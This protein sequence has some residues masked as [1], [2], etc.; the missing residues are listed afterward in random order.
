MSE[1]VRINKYMPI[2]ILYFFFNGFLLPQG[3]LYTAIL[4]PVLLLWLYK[5]PSFKYIKYFFL[6]TIP[7]AI[8]HFINGVVTSYYLIS[9]SLLFTVFVFGLSF[10][11][12]LLICKSYRRI[13]SNLVLLNFVFFL[14]AVIG[15]TIPWLKQLLWTSSYMSYNIE[16]VYR[17]RM[18]TYE[19]SYYSTLLVPIAVYYYIKALRNQLTDWFF[20][21]LMVS[22][23]LLLSF[24]FGVISGMI[25]ALAVMLI[26]NLGA[27]FGKRKAA[28]YILIG[29]SL[30]FA[31]L[32]V[33]FVFFPDNIFFQRL[34]NVFEGR[35]SS[36]RG[37]THDSLFLAWEVAKMKSTIFGVGL[38]QT[39]VLGLDLWREF[40]AFNF[41]QDQIAIPNVLG[42]TL[43]TFG[44][45]GIVIRIGLEIYFFF[46]SRVF[47]NYYRLTLFIFAFIYQFTGSYLY[48]IAEIAI[49]VL[50]FTNI[51]PEFDKPKKAVEFEL[52]T[53]QS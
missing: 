29:T 12:F 8:I 16:G 37:R 48:N 46:K 44:I 15:L 24:S 43:A 23:P 49:W 21:I 50:A 28:L 27:F 7:F 30:L 25:L 53:A 2:A 26:L 18:L 32:I 20:I 10:Y 19:P 45:A 33:A 38:G 4:T 6:F 40:Y 34:S 41:S 51:F 22:L 14:I 3:L 13:Y 52:S 11:Q 47:S 35:D 17:L 5:F 1:G 39:K 9:F 31:S 36:F 42:D